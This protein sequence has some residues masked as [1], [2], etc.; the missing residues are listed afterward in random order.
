[1]RCEHHD[2]WIWSWSPSG[3][4]WQ[5]SMRDA[6]GFGALYGIVLGVAFALGFAIGGL[7]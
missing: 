4:V 6:L 7:K 2:G 1:M 3:L 5:V